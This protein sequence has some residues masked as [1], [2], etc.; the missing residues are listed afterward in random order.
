[1]IQAKCKELTSYFNNSVWTFAE[2]EKTD[3]KRVVTARWVLTWKDDLDPET[4]ITKKKAKARLVLRGF[5]D[6]DLFSLEKTSPTVSKHAKMILLNLSVLFNWGVFCGDVKCA[7]LSGAKFFR[8]I[9]VKLPRDCSPLLGVEG[10]TFMKMNKSAYGLSDAPRLWWCEADRRL[11]SIGLV[12]H[13]LDKCCYMYYNAED[14][15]AAMVIMHVD[16]LLIGANMK[17]PAGVKV[18]EEIKKIFDF[19]KWQELK[20]NELLVYCGGHIR[21]KEN[22]ITLDFESYLR[23][24]MPITIPKGRSRD[25]PLTASEV[26]KVRGLIGAL[27][28]PAG[29]GC[30]HLCAS[31]S[32]IAANVN[33]GDFEIM[34]DLNMAL[35]F[36]KSAADV[37]VQMKKVCD[38]WDDLCL[39]CFSDAAVEVRP[40]GGSQ[41]GYVI[42]ATSKDVLT[43]KVVPYNTVAWRSY[44]LTRVCRSSLSAES[45]A[46]ATA[47]DELMMLKTML[48]IIKNPHADPKKESTAADVCQSVVV[49]DAKGLFDAIHKDG[50]GS[51]SDKRAGIE[52]LCIQEELRRQKTI[53]RWVSSERMLADGMTKI[54]TRQE[55]VN[56]LKSG[57]MCLVDDKTFT[58]A[59]KKDKQTRERSTARTFGYGSRIA[60]QIST[61]IAAD[62]IA[63]AEGHSMDENDAVDWGFIVTI[64]VLVLGVYVTCSAFRWLILQAWT[65]IKK[66]MLVKTQAMETQTETG[67]PDDDDSDDPGREFNPAVVVLK[68]RVKILEKM[69]HEERADHGRHEAELMEQRDQCQREA[70]ETDVRLQGLHREHD[71]LQTAFRHLQVRSRTLYSTE[72]YFTRQ[73]RVWNA[74]RE[75]HALQGSEHILSKGCLCTFC[76]SRLYHDTG[77]VTF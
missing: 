59:K 50:V 7:F 13:R 23:K 12:R 45:Q 61:V 31:T 33:K 64:V 34:N 16:D 8:E 46:C 55:M 29:Q 21:K 28:W 19:G 53:L 20:E 24:V 6:P 72:C 27:Q 35:R 5:E 22:G 58:A 47:L 66:K 67:A 65:W 30:P 62:A 49:I 14:M 9:I 69:L 73:G 48:A 41:G 10:T 75:C 43:G 25:A 74:F 68:E 2:F 36:A 1:M 51:A 11:R 52:I 63:R 4:G 77:A 56:M 32:I 26:S 70:W 42:V 40:D 71:E 17:D 76:G 54:H 60:E 18:I 15:V 3:Q 37:P 38:G 39:V 44:K 57:F